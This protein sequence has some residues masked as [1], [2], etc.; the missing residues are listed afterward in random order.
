MG[1]GV[2][3]WEVEGSA[4]EQ[5]WEI[6]SEYLDWSADL[7]LDG[8]GSPCVHLVFERFDLRQRSVEL[9]PV[10]VTAGV[11]TLLMPGSSGVV[12]GFVLDLGF[13]RGQTP[14]D[15]KRFGTSDRLREW[16]LWSVSRGSEHRRDAARH[17]ALRV[18]RIL[19]GEIPAE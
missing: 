11:E 13:G 19:N 18:A 16:G 9:S 4:W 15:A 8:I 1:V 5:A 6:A 10:A 2:E 14:S 17:L 3:T 7:V 12:A